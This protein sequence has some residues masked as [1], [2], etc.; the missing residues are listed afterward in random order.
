MP[1]GGYTIAL[2]FVSSLS[3][4]LAHH[5]AFVHSSLEC[6]CVTKHRPFCDSIAYGISVVSLEAVGLY[7]VSKLSIILKRF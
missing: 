3:Q 4:V 6:S 5:L 2:R 7:T 1:I